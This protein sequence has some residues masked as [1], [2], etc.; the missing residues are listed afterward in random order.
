MRPQAAALKALLEGSE[1]Y[2]MPG[3]GDGMGARLVAEAGF[4]VG[5]ASGSSISAMKLGMPDMDLLSFPEM[6]DA[7]ANVVTAAPSVLWL[8]DGDTGYGNEF[9]VQRTVREYARLG[10]AAVLIEDKQ[11]PRPLAKD[12]AKLTIERDAAT[13]RLTAAIH[14]AKEEGVL[15]LARTDSRPSRGFEEALERIKIFTALGADI[16]FLDSPAS[17]EEQRAAV[18]ASGGKPHISVTSPSGKPYTA[19]NADLAANG[20]K[21]AIYPQEV[22]SA[23]VK[24]I[25]ATLAGLHAGGEPIGLETPANLAVAVRR[26]EYLA[27]DL[28]LAG[29][30][31]HH[32]GKIIK[33]P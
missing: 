2:L 31:E 1:M 32:V 21:I 26:A 19:I 8:G 13:L 4:K 28:R 7:V 22:L 15:L 11:W 29:M 3:V 30:T 5:F 25:R 27:A 18:A 10:C 33:L 23:T 16:L 20:I 24:A 14:A 9:A 6:R 17:G 12:G